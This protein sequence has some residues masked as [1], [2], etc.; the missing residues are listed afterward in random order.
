MKAIAVAAK[1]VH[2]VNMKQHQKPRIPNRKPRTAK[3]DRAKKTCN[4]CGGNHPQQKERCPAWG[5]KCHKC[6]GRN[7]F[8]SKCRK[9][10]SQ[11]HGISHQEHDHPESDV[12]YIT[13]VGVNTETVGAVE[14]SGYQ[15][16][17]Y[18]EMLIDGTAVNRVR[19][20]LSNQNSRTFQGQF[21]VYQGLKIT[22]IDISQLNSYFSAVLP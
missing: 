4:F 18:A 10:Q 12:D 13:S 1:D 19:T 22:F 11:I 21:L 6:G 9:P 14:Q 7:H 2:K 16:E 8:A 3:D 5:Q 17:I 15:R 20:A